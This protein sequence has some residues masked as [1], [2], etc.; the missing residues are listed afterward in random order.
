MQIFRLGSLPSSHYQN[1]SL[2]FLNLSLNCIFAFPH[3]GYYVCYPYIVSGLSSLIISQ[4][5]QDKNH[6]P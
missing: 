1:L 4:N 5:F 3:T 2:E 6:D